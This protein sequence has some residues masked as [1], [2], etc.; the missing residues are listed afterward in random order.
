MGGV[1]CHHVGLP[2]ERAFGRK[3]GSSRPSDR[4]MLSQ[5]SIR[6]IGLPVAIV[7]STA[8]PRG[9]LP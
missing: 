7:T 8:P 6:P 2:Q 3:N 1:D 5:G 9:G 4:L